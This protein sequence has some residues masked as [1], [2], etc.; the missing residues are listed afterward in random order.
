[1]LVHPP[2]VSSDFSRPVQV[3]FESSQTKETSCSDGVK[4]HP[5][6][7]NA[8]T[9]INRTE[10]NRNDFEKR[11]SSR[12]VA[13]HQSQSQSQLLVAILRNDAGYVKSFLQEETQKG[14]HNPGMLKS[15]SFI[16][17][18]GRYKELSNISID[19]VFAMK[20]VMGDAPTVLHLA[21]LN[22]YCRCKQ[23]LLPRYL[24]PHQRRIEV[25]KAK[26]IINLLML[27]MDSEQCQSPTHFPVLETVDSTSTIQTMT[28]VSPLG[29]LERIRQMTK[30]LKW[31]KMEATIQTVLV[32][33]GGCPDE[34]ESSKE[35]S[36]C[37][38]VGKHNRRVIIDKVHMSEGV[39]RPPTKESEEAIKRET[40]DEICQLIF[41]NL[42]GSLARGDTSNTSG[43]SL[44]CASGLVL[45][46]NDH[47]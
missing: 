11:S 3:T 24:L 15:S 38:Q 21:I 19:H 4:S 8:K 10:R 6:S 42:G 18:I 23:I 17:S 46:F 34:H 13:I 40:L 28:V 16:F 32:D 29:L 35:G 39:E 41:C 30:E 37:E 36:R 45:L 2:R 31:K 12:S 20:K 26:I 44:T 25:D 22:L 33:M 7:S 1:M 5:K 47:E 14:C 43:T 9:P 27:H